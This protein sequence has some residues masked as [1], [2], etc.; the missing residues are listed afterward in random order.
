MPLFVQRFNRSLGVSSAIC[1]LK[2]MDTKTAKCIIRGELFM[3]PIPTQPDERN[4]KGGNAVG[5]TEAAPRLSLH[6]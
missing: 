3:F 5:T 4:K 2:A 6:H 1:N